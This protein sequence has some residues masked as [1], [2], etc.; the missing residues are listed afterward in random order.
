[1]FAYQ[2]GHKGWLPTY[3]FMITVLILGVFIPLFL[4][5]LYCWPQHSR[6]IWNQTS[7][8]GYFAVLQITLRQETE[9]GTWLFWCL[10]SSVCQTFC[11]DN[12]LMRPRSHLFPV[13]TPRYCNQIGC[14][15][16]G[17][18]GVETAW[19]RFLHKYIY[20]PDSTGTVRIILKMLITSHCFLNMS[21]NQAVILHL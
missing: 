18:F 2:T 14:F 11:S 7:L 6:D 8:K 3:H 12:T 20:K 19:S 13:I 21:I 9:I 15:Y 4:E 17:F 16:W 1:M 5:P 10:H